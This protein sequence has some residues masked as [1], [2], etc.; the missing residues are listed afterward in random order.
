MYYDI[1]SCDFLD[2]FLKGYIDAALWS[3]SDESR[4]DGGDPLDSNY[5]ERDLAKETRAKMRADCEAFICANVE[6]LKASQEVYE[7]LAAREGAEDFWPAWAGHDFWLTR[8]HHGAGFWDRGLGV[9][10]DRLTE[11]A[12]SF[13][14]KNLYVHRKRI[15]QE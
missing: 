2:V 5:S 15:Y 8:N 13:R 12:E 6:D 11:S 1:P 3:S 7:D 14:E 4:P 9:I 10:G